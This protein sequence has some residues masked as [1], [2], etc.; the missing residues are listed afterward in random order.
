MNQ[1]NKYH[2]RDATIRHTRL[3]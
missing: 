2:H 3:S 1:E